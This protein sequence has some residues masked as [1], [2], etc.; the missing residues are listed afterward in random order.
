MRTVGYVGFYG[1]REPAFLLPLIATYS[2]I[3]DS[4]TV[5]M[6]KQ[7]MFLLHNLK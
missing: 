6:F 3:I 5:I 2:L 1:R 7:F 4:L